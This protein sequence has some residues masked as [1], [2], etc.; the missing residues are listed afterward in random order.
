LVGWIQ[1]V[2]KLRRFAQMTEQIIR[3]ICVNLRINSLR[4]L[5]RAPSDWAIY[6][7]VYSAAA[8]AVREIF[9]FSQKNRFSRLTVFFRW[10]PC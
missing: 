7:S 6:H 10:L 9:A 3:G 1:I 8:I 2:R 5:M 4:F